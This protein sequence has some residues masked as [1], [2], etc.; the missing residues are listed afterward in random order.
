MG[1]VMKAHRKVSLKTRVI[2]AKKAAVWKVRQSG[3]IQFVR[4]ALATAVGFGIVLAA[5]EVL[6]Y[7][8]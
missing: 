3:V 2:R 1:G 8:V 6:R 5:L 4:D 7:V